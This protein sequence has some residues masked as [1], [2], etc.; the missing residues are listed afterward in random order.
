MTAR[1]TLNVN[2]GTDMIHREHPFEECNVDDAE[3]I[4]RVDELTAVRMVASG[5]AVACIHCKP[6]EETA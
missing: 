3:D 2:D 4:E 5:Q 1:F 6:M